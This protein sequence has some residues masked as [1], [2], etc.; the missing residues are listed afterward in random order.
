LM[1][2]GVTKLRQK[3]SISRS[4][5]ITQHSGSHFLPSQKHVPLNHRHIELHP[6]KIFSVLSSEEDPS[7]G[8]NWLT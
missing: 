4:Q 1:T 6:H 3:Y 5:I 2:T 7:K 8:S